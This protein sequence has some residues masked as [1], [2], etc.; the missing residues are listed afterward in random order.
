MITAKNVLKFKRFFRNYYEQYG[1]QFPWR[2]NGTPAFHLLIAEMLLRQTKA[3]QVAAIWPEVIDRFPTPETLVNAR[4]DE[5]FSLVQPL[6]LGH[7]RADALISMSNALVLCFGSEVPN[8][9]QGLMD[10][11]HVG[12]YSAAA[13]SCFAFGHQTP[14]VDA[15]VLRLLGRIAGSDFGRDNRRSPEVWEL[16]KSILPPR[17]PRE[18]NYGILDFSAQ[19]CIYRAPKCEECAILRACAFG[20]SIT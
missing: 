13:V 9:Y 3:T 19:I 14:V 10:L 5:L 12:M 17:F 8:S 11:P 20:S 18:H 4:L 7:Q 2:E 16:A 15:N 6:G 1:R